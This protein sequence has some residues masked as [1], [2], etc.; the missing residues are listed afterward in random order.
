MIAAVVVCV[1]LAA[2]CAILAWFFYIRSQAAEDEVRRYRALVVDLRDELSAMTIK[3]RN[4]R[5][6]A[7]AY[8]SRMRETAAAAAQV[9]ARLQSD[10][11]EKIAE[12]I[13]KALDL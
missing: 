1:L 11:P 10:D 6:A 5:T 2:L 12:A 9:E 8:V 3:A 13:N 4:E 7:D